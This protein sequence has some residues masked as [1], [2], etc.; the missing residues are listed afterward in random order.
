MVMKLGIIRR[1]DQMYLVLKCGGGD[2]LGWSCDK[3]RN[4]T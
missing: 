3:W 2:Q 1:V 4:I